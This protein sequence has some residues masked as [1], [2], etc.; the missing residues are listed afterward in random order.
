MIVEFNGTRGPF[1]GHCLKLRGDGSTEIF[2]EVMPPAW[3]DSSNPLN[4]HRRFVEA[5]Q[6]GTPVEVSG[7]EGKVDVALAEQ[8]YATAESVIA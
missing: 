8:V 7:E 3:D 6:Q 4:Q 2:E 5:L 1:Q